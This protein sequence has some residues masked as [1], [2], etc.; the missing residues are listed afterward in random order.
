L[1]VQQ[2]RKRQDSWTATATSSIAR[3]LLPLC[4]VVA[5]CLSIGSAYLFGYVLGVG[6]TT[7]ALVLLGSVPAVIAALAV[8]RRPELGVALLPLVAAAVPITI[9]TGT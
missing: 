3:Y 8:L 9:G 1:S 2:L 4:L 7:L 6:K 5:V